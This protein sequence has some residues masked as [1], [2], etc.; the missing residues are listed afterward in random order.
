MSICVEDA[1]DPRQP[2]T[3][4]KP[5][6]MVALTATRSL[7]KN[8]LRSA[9]TFVSSRSTSHT[10]LESSAQSVFAATD[11][12]TYSGTPKICR[13]VAAVASWPSSGALLPVADF[14]FDNANA[15]AGFVTNEVMVAPTVSALLIASAAKSRLAYAEPLTYVCIPE[16]APR[17]DGAGAACAPKKASSTG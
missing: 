12:L 7:V 8:T 11:G 6:R 16:S 4:P 14:T 13:D 5:T 9:S 3:R 15:V 17:P 1:L 2:C 10:R